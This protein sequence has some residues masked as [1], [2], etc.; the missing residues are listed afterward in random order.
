VS[1]AVHAA[2]LALEKV[3]GV[4]VRAERRMLP[5]HIVI[6]VSY[7]ETSA[8]E[9]SMWGAGWAGQGLER[10]HKVKVVYCL[11]HLTMAWSKNVDIHVKDHLLARE[12]KDALKLLRDI[13][14]RP[15][16]VCHRG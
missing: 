10:G 9:G 11:W 5:S 8:I 1:G 3:S 16:L 6:D 7:T 14:V 12:I 2:A 15:R 4:P 13:P